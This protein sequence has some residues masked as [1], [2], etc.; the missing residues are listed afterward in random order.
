MRTKHLS[1][2]FIKYPIISNNDPSD[3]QERRILSST[4]SL[5]FKYLTIK[6]SSSSWILSLVGYKFT[7]KLSDPRD[8]CSEGSASF[9]APFQVS[10]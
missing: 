9:F 8:V 3:P 10:H 5:L 7:L 6:L 2:S 1:L 4:S